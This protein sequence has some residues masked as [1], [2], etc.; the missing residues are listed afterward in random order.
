MRYR[1]E[2]LCLSITFEATALAIRYDRATL[3]DQ[4]RS[5]NAY[6]SGVARRLWF[7]IRYE[8]ATLID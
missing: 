2:R 6:L 8:A 3:I 5:I 4:V 7:S 1:Y